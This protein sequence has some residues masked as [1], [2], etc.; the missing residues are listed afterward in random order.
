M[1]LKREFNQILK[2]FVLVG[3]IKKFLLKNQQNRRME[4]VNFPVL[5]LPMKLL[6]EKGC[7]EGDLWAGGSKDAKSN[8]SIKKQFFRS[9]VD[10]IELKRI[11][12]DG[13][14]VDSRVLLWTAAYLAAKKLSN[15]NVDQI[16]TLNQRLTNL[17]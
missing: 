8:Y 9:G 2:N 1:K 11:K 5:M 15:W 16:L 3:E 17:A 10:E 4:K 6:D 13:E 7:R 14:T 12:I